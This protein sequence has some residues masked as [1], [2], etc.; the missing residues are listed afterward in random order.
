MTQNFFGKIARKQ[1]TTKTAN[2]PLKITAKIS[3]EM[4]KINWHR[5][6]GLRGISP[7]KILK[8]QTNQP[9]QEDQALKAHFPHA[10]PPS[11]HPPKTHA[12][13]VHMSCPFLSGYIRALRLARLARALRSVRVMR[14]MR[15][16][17]VEK[18]WVL[19]DIDRSIGI[20]SS[21]NQK[22]WIFTNNHWIE[23]TFIFFWIYC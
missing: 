3:W 14:F 21:E 9:K 7:L 19:R 4:Q 13:L 11:S 15:R 22:L 23:A 16:L 12:S 18:Y 6:D 2:S 8:L 1:T 20:Y 17:G 5:L 10:M